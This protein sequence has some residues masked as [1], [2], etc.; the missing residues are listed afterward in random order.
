MKSQRDPSG[1]EHSPKVESLT[2]IEGV[3]LSTLP[4]VD[5][6]EENRLTELYRPEWTGVFKD[7]EPIEHLYT[8]NA[9][10]GGIRKEWYYHEHTIDR[11]MVLNGLLDIGLYDGRTNSKTR[12]NF[13]VI[14]LGEPGS[15]LPNA[16][17][18][19][20]FVWHSLKWIT[21]QG[22]FLNAKLPGYSRK[23]TD[24]FRVQSADLPQEIKW[25]I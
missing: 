3:V 14:S 9:P 10:K 17:R 18:I 21:P 20:A 1:P 16:I 8:V 7:Q 15:D 25:N 2:D 22:M 19:P 4:F 24:K 13:I 5:Y 23:I 11:Y 6:G 12:N